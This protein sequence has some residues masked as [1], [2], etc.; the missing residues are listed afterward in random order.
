MPAVRRQNWKDGRYRTDEVS[1]GWRM[2]PW[3]H[4]LI[5]VTKDDSILVT[6]LRTNNTVKFSESELDDLVTGAWPP[7]R[8]N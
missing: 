6:N 1:I 7:W 2:E 3:A 5:E 4:I 8:W